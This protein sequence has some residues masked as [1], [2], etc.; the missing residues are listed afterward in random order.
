M[1]QKLVEGYEVTT[2][3]ILKEC[4]ARENTCWNDSTARW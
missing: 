1:L 2:E 3:G 4:N